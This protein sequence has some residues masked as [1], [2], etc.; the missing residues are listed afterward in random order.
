MI[1]INVLIC[2]RVVVCL[3]FGFLIV[4]MKDGVFNY[5]DIEGC[6]YFRVGEGY[7]E[8]LIVFFLI[9]R[10]L[11]IL[12]VIKIMILKSLYFNLYYWVRCCVFI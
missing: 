9:V 11:I 1:I 10:V 4:F 6:V 3:F 2:S 8:F 7:F 12:T 5:I